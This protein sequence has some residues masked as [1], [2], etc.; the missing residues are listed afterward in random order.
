[1]KKVY[2]LLILSCL[3]CLTWSSFAQTTTL[4]YTGS[5]QTFTVGSGVNFLAIDMAGAQGGNGCNST[6]YPGG[7]GGR[8]QCT[9]AVTPGQ[10]LTIYVGGVGGYTGAGYNG[11]GTGSS[12]GAGGGGA[13][14]IRMNGTTTANRVLVAGGGGGGACYCG[15]AGGAGGGLSGANG[16]YCGSNNTSYNGQ[17]GSPTAGGAGATISGGTGGFGTGGN[18]YCCAYGGGGGGGWYGGGG[19]YYGSGGGGSSYASPTLATGVQHTQGYQ[20]SSGYVSITPLVP[21]VTSSPTSL[22]FGAVLV[23]ATSSP[24]VFAL[25]GSILNVGGSLTITPPSANFQV[26]PDGVTWYTN[27]TPYT[28]TYS[29]TGFTSLFMYARFL[30]SAVTSYSGNIAITGG[31]L[32]ATVNI[33]VTGAG[34]NACTGTPTAGTATISPSSGSSTT[35]FTLG[36]SGASVAGGITYQW[37]SAPSSGGTYVD[38]PGATTATY[39][40]TGLSA[41]TW[42]KCTET[43]PT[44][45][46]SVSTITNATFTLPSSSCIP[47]SNTNCTG[48]GFFVSNNTT[49]P[50]IITGASGTLTDNSIALSGTGGSIY[51]YNNVSMNVSFNKGSTYTC[52]AGG[53]TS[54]PISYSVWIDFNNSGTFETSELVGGI[55]HY[56]TSSARAVISLPIPASAPTG[57]FRMRVLMNY[58][59]NYAPGASASYP[60][61]PQSPPC[62]TTTV[63]YADTRDY[64]AIILPGTP[65]LTAT[66]MGTFGNVTVGTN[67]LPVGVTKLSG[68]NLL[69]PTGLLSV[70]APTNFQVSSNGVAWGSSAT[71]PYTGGSTNANVYV[72][73][74]PTVAA[75]SS[76]NVGISGGGVSGTY[77][78]AVTGT[79]TS[80]ACSGTPT[81]GAASASPSSG[82]PG[83][84]FTLSLT[85]AS[86]SG[87]LFYQWQSSPTGTTWTNIPNGI[88]PTYTFSGL[89]ATTQFRCI[90]TC[91]T[92]AS[93]TSSA[94]TVTYSAS[95]ASSSCTPNSYTNCTGCG[96]FVSNGSTYPC[97]ITGAGATLTDNSNALGGTGGSSYYYNNTSM[98]V[99]FNP[100]GTYSATVGGLTTNPISHSVWIDF[101]NSGTFET[102]ELVGGVAHYNTSSAR[103]VL[104]LQIPSTAP[105]GAFR[106]RVVMNYDA[107]YAPGANTGYPCYPLQNPCPGNSS[108][109]VYYAD[110][111]DYTAII[112]DPIYCSGVPNPGIVNAAPA[113]ACAAFT[114]NM[115]NVG[116]TPSLGMTYQ[117]QSSSSPTS[118]FT[119]IS[120]ATNTVYVPSLSSVGTIY[121]RDSAS[122]TSSA[123]SAVSP[124]MALTLNSAPAA[125]TGTAVICNSSSSTL[126]CATSGGSWS[127]SNSSVASVGSSTGTVTGNSVGTATISYILPTGCFSTKV[128]TI[129]PQPAAITGTAVACGGT[130]ATSVTLSD[131]T[132][133]GLWSSSNVVL[134]TVGST[135]GIVTGVSGGN[136]VITYTLPTGC[137]STYPMTIN[138]VAAISGVTGI[139]IGNT[140]TLSDATGGGSWTSSNTSV[141]TIGSTGAVASF[142]LGSTT[143][144]YT[145]ASM[146]CAAVT[147]VYVTNTPAVYSITGGGNYCSGGTGVHIGMATTDAYVSYTLFN[148]ATMVS[149]L[150]GGGSSLDFGLLTGAGTYGVV[151]NYGTPCATTMS[152]TAT[153]V[154]NPLPTAYTVSGGGAYCAGGAGVHIYLNSSTVGTNYQ[155]TLGTTPIGSPLAGTG[156]ALDFGLVTGVGTYTVVGINSATSCVNNM[157]GSVA[158]SINPLPTSFSL[159]GG[160][161]YC[162]GGTGVHVGLSGS[163]SGTSYQLML[164]GSPAGT[165]MSGTGIALDFGL[166]TTGGTYSVVATNTTTGCATNMSGTATVVVNPLPTV[167]TVTGGGG[168]CTGGTGVPVGLNGS[169]S[170][171]NYQLFNGT[172]SVGAAVA[173]SGAAISFGLQTTTGSY[174]VVATNASTGCVNNMS[175]SVT[176]SINPLP[177]SFSVTG[178][179]GYC[180]GGSGVPVGLSGSVVGT[181][182][183]LYNGGTLVGAASGTGG[184]ISFGLQLV[185]GVYTVVG[186]NGLT[187]CSNNMS[188]SV[189]ITINP[190]PTVYTLTG[191]GNY[192]AGGTGVVVGLSGSQSGV[193]Y[194]LY[195]GGIAM[196]SPVA[197]TGGAISFGPQTTAGTY[198]AVAVNTSTTCAINMTG[199]ATIAINP[200]PVVYGVTGGGGYCAGSTGVHVGL[201]SSN[202]GISY[203]L[204]S[205]SAVGAPLS[206]TGATL[207]FGIFT[208]PGS[209]T[210]VAT[211]TG[212]GCTNTMGGSA[213]VA[214]NAVPAPFTLNSA[215]TSYCAGGAGVVFGLGG[216]ATGVN[217]QLYVGGLATGSVVAGT[218][219]AISFGPQ[220]TPGIYTAKAV[221]AT[222]GC[223]SNMTGSITININ[224]LPAL[225]AVTGGGN[226]CS[227][228]TGVTVGL[229][230]SVVGV[231]YQLM[232]GTSTV[233]TPLAGTGGPLSYGPQTTSGV[234][235]IVATSPAT[236]CSATMTGSA[237][238]NVDPLP[239]PFTV[240]GGG[241]YCAGGP[242]VHLGL[243]G[244][245]VG[246]SY[247][248]YAGGS[249]AGVAL[250]GT[251]LALDFGLQ[252]TPA[253]YTVVGTNTTTGCVALMTGSPV[254]AVS[255][256]P[257]LH[258]VVGGGNYCV[259][260]TGVTIGLDGSNTGT[261]YQLYLGAV[262]VGPAVPGSTGAPVSFGPQTATGIYTVIATNAT[263][264]CTNNMTG[265]VTVGTSPLPVV[266]NVTGGGNYCS[267]G[268]GVHI[269]LSGSNTGVMYSLYNGTSLVGSPF[270]GTGTAIDFG[271][272][273][274]SGTYTVVAANITTS[275][276]NTMS[277]SATV[278][279]TTLP[280]VFNVTGGGN[281][282]AG[283]TGVHIG[284]SGSASGVNYQLYNGTTAIGT[285]VPGSGAALDFG[286][287][288]AA[289]T[290]TVLATSASSTCTNLMSGSV[291]I[292]INP[293]PTAYTATGGGNYC[294]GGAGVDIALG[295]SDPGVNYQLYRGSVMVGPALSGTGYSLDFGM[296]TT[297]GTYTIVATDGI[298]TCTNNMTGSIVVN[299][300]PL[301][302]AFLVTGGGN[303]CAGGPG[304]HVMLGGSATGVLYQ[305]MR[306]TS[307]VGAALAGTGAVL[308]FGLQTTPGTYTVVATNTTTTCTNTMS[309]SVAIGINPLPSVYSVSSSTTNYCAGGG[310]VDITLSNSDPGVSYQLYNGFTA[311]GAPLS[312]TGLALDFGFWLPAGVYSVVATNNS[313]GCSSTMY[314]GV[315]ITVN[316]LPN[317][318]NV[319][320]GGSYCNGGSGV[321]VGLSGSNPGITYQLYVGS[322]MVGGALAGTGG[323]ID[324]GLQTTPGNYTIVATNTSTSC[325]NNM[326]GSATVVANALPAN[327]DV[328]GGG[329]YCAGGSGVH[330]T[331][332]GSSTGVSYQLYRAGL[333]I[334]G[335]PVAGS[336]A[337]LDFGSVT[338][339]GTYT[340]VATNVATS[341]SSNM[342]GSASVAIDAAPTAHSVT[343]GGNYCPGGTGVHVG[344][345]ASN[346]GISYQLYNGT[347]AV[348]A[349]MAGTGLG[350]LDFGLQTTSGTYTVVATNSTTGCTSNMTG[351]AA[352]VINT[353]PT[354]YN[355]IGGGSFCNGGAGVHIGLASS[356]VGVNYRLYSSFTGLSIVAGTGGPIDF[357]LVAAGGT[358]T[359]IGTNVST[360]CS[361]NMTGTATVTVNPAVTPS[362]A[363]S[364][365]VGDTI[366]EGSFI[367]FTTS[368]AHGGST[369]AFHWTINGVAAGTSANYGYIPVNGDVIA[370][371]MTSTEMCATPVTVTASKT[372]T[373]DPRKLPVVNINSNP[374]SVVC[375]GTSVTFTAIPAY[376]GNNPT[377]AWTKNG[378]SAGT[379]GTLTYV[380]SN[381]DVISCVL[382]SDYH[383]RLAPTATSPVVTM[384]VDQPTAPVVTIAANP[385][386]SISAGQAVTFTATV[387]N[388]GPAPAYQWLVNGSAVTGATGPTYT[389]ANLFDGDSVACHVLSSGGC[390]GLLGTRSVGVHVIGVGVHE[391]NSSSASDI[392]LIPNPNKGVF[393]VKGTLGTAT[394]EDVTIEITDML[395]QVIYKTKAEARNG[396][397]NQRVQLSSAVANGMYILNL[398]SGSDMKIFHIVVEQ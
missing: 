192:C 38:I 277:G 295:G 194:Q 263:T 189:T 16:I 252:T 368:I 307:P 223:S 193:G 75:T 6:S 383:C 329:N 249:P 214:V 186:T 129:N 127:S 380:P 99:N 114:A 258:T 167:F 373:V 152:G 233:G 285:A 13:S 140:T 100:G 41:N 216:S 126:I 160:G 151:A 330:V 221:D 205:G 116:V 211:N 45:G 150:V 169:T 69:A 105:K 271:L 30:P 274:S 257:A 22:T 266:Y 122:C 259:G 273:T 188:G 86:T 207:D 218:G 254:V 156:S 39:V 138:A 220:T 384:E 358:Y 104:T 245:A 183:Q 388:G 326:T 253:T 356:A 49:Y 320:G 202:S 365:G 48:C 379:L 54:N 110:T 248:L 225:F 314:G 390:P 97:I 397:I 327:Y 392:K 18:A 79:G 9:L 318:Y 163:V 292:N 128:V 88:Y 212:S 168:Y 173:G 58:D 246:I 268:T 145:V 256:L 85:G 141:A 288:T 293:L 306:G 396:E 215:G 226:Y 267:G 80:T 17:G 370:V 398:R 1:M 123:S 323:P 251:G 338:M 230:G 243:G 361:S 51:Y 65:T 352:V 70:S 270:S 76:G 56:R 166:I 354:A 176:V 291:A 201:A 64:T 131:A 319:T 255:V 102:S 363:I 84:S 60:C 118:G 133:G 360:G 143:I 372:M 61:Y 355:V 144:S 27:T 153:V 336:G 112:S 62:P 350:S 199:S 229:S 11:G 96:F 272:Y 74:S 382:T 210:V 14:D 389:S 8:L 262:A 208:T 130:G 286:L 377:Y 385:G 265:S 241:N 119:N 371:T 107:N 139:C 244:S 83:T 275:C 310:G 34:A 393:T 343:G 333:T 52:T 170:G 184:A 200:L 162:V 3:G 287:R 296:Q 376:G 142:G 132:T 7:K 298:T 115:F 322:S 148:G 172:T 35:A 44:Y 381:G 63:Y 299:I 340:V 250:A 335:A 348:G 347:T 72:Q 394:D 103:A 367:N 391:V 332:N 2:F 185:A 55:A 351:S 135:S 25:N 147:T 125:I 284:L 28:Y 237:V 297:A 357:G 117:W 40:Y 204:M 309:G 113:S 269:G 359:V 124:A 369:P 308:D 203:Q 81:A 180:A 154:V 195:N 217:Y 120:G 366:C 378:S 19:G 282:C 134:A 196:G 111:R 73:F 66:S 78:V 209:Y 90:V 300:T 325:T 387:V 32:T 33:P 91:G 109:N 20:T 395:G 31:G 10:V 331:L 213:V 239:G 260:G 240:T 47:T 279:T 374:G 57:A 92:G 93:A 5:A 283:G 155:L 353:L 164:G 313:T 242:G 222:T 303:Y 236:D 46:P 321:H 42:F 261:N 24:A 12:S 238:V 247:Q 362:V 301:P 4:N 198:T 29:G 59:A 317:A 342:A 278:G 23:G 341:C 101:N 174:S 219:S 289:G 94:A 26:S 98:S 375:Q 305:L 231:N 77:N 50:C 43:C 364:T 171:V 232:N 228:G 344:L 386:L 82:G 339:A 224:P 328:T 161:G 36:L 190:L 106:M 95:I 304:L 53:L 182:Y 280:A 21:T 121:Y 337:T 137:V 235:T 334:V 181:N 89:I 108:S 290:Y 312:G 178:G 159:T 302:A 276:T 346:T 177:T 227:G 37:Q 264:G 315:T 87:G 311:M 316:P 294:A 71:I 179:G 165:A 157:S 149:T 191:G 281:Y 67:S 197:G 136:P 175:G 146:G 349:P 234:Y 324:F 187:G 15:E 68:A 206:G 158:V 345:G